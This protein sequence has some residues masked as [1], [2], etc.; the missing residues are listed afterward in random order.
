MGKILKTLSQKKPC[1]FT[2]VG[3]RF[4]YTPPNKAD[5]ILGQTQ[6]AATIHIKIL[7]QIN[8][9]KTLATENNEFFFFN[10]VKSA[11]NPDPIF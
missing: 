11:L 2:A 6:A 4:K 9:K 3:A 1:I 7:Q 8:L 10:L 5:T